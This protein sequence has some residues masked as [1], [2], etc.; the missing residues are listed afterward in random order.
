MVTIVG[1]PLGLGL[2][3]GFLPLV[4]FVGYL[5]AAIWLGE[6]VVRQFG[7]GSQ[8]ER[9]YLAAIVG[10]LFLSAISFVPMVGGVISF[11]GFGAVILLMWR[12]L[13]R[14]PLEVA[15]VIQPS[16]ASAAS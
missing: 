9:P 12:T 7:R 13:R 16:V 8:P 5:V 10:I 3:I 14:Q 2:L 6:W 11:V 1:I 4:A 15:G